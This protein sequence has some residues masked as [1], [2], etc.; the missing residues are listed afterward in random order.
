MMRRITYRDPETG[1]EFSFMT[2]EFTV[3]PGLFA[4][5]CKLR[6]D[7]EKAFDEKEGAR[8]AARMALAG[9]VASA[10]GRR[11]NPLVAGCARATGRS[12]QFIRWL[13]YCLGKPRR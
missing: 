12:L 13:R 2:S 5:I 10:A 8:R 3:P 6:W 7:I 11:T 9:R 1:R 4:F